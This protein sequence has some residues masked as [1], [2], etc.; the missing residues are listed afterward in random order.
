ME[1]IRIRTSCRCLIFFSFQ[2]ILQTKQ[3]RNESFNKKNDLTLRICCDSLEVFR[4]FLGR[5]AEFNPDFQHQIPT[6]FS[7]APTTDTSSH[8]RIHRNNGFR[9]TSEIKDTI[10]TSFN[11]FTYRRHEKQTNKGARTKTGWNV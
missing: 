1:P 4:S 11:K 6:F 3:Q 8:V 7:S 5:V 9:T 10:K 2:I